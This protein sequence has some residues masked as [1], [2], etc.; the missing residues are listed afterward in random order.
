[1]GVQINPHAII[2]PKIALAERTNGLISTDSQC[3]H[4]LNNEYIVSYNHKSVQYSSPSPAR[5]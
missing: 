3:P 5:S 4:I 2:P 1:M